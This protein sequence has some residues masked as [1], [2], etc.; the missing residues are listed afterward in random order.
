MTSKLNGKI[1]ND[2]SSHCAQS[3]EVLKLK[4]IDIPFSAEICKWIPKINILTSSLCGVL[5]KFSLRLETPYVALRL[6]SWN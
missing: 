5:L 3:T 4:V 1:N 6:F 2:E